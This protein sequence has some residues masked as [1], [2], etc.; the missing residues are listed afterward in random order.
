M[1]VFQPLTPTLDIP[2]STRVR[3]LT[4]ARSCPTPNPKPIRV[5]VDGISKEEELIYTS[6]AM[7]MCRGG[8]LVFRPTNERGILVTSTYAHQ[9]DDSQF[10][11]DPFPRDFEYYLSIALH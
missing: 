6:E 11:R 1:V 3:A 2:L 4:L 7:L 5:R 10:D 8:M 9:A